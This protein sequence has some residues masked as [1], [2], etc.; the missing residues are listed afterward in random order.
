MKR[1]VLTPAAYFT[2]PNHI[3]AKQLKGNMPEQTQGNTKPA[4]WF[5]RNRIASNLRITVAG[6]LI[7]AAMVSAIAS[8]QP[9]AP[10]T[11]LTNDNGANG[12]TS[13]TTRSRPATPTPTRRS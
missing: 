6:T 8:F 13:A 2:K 9:A 4:H 1:P 11:R 5:D 3:H 12:A 10:N 7:A